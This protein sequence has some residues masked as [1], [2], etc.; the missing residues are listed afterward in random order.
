MFLVN[1]ADVT[2]KGRRKYGLIT[3]QPLMIANM[4]GYPTL[5][6]PSS[7]DSNPYSLS[8]KYAFYAISSN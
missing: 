5:Q 1:C 6:P 7:S 8:N 3:G 4:I 2:I